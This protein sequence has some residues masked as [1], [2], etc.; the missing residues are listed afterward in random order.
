[1]PVFHHGPVELAFLDEGQGEP[2]VLVHG[3][4]STKEVNWVQPGWIATLNGA[5]RRVIALD[6][7]GH[8]AVDAS[9]TIRPTITPRKWP[10]TCARCSIISASSAPTSWAIRWARGSP[11]SWR[12]SIPTACARWCWAGSACTWSMAW[13]CP[14]ASPRRWRRRRS[15]T[16]AIRWAARSAPSPTRPIPTAGRSPPASAAR[17]RR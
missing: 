16:S 10:R 3:F 9:S 15:P 2:I 11:P 4:A 14:R 5:G 8:G 7:R 6:N 13:A 12:S 1:M 17:A